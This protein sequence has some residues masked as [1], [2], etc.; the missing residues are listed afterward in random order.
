M[1]GRKSNLGRGLFSLPPDAVAS[2][3]E[4]HSDRGE[5]VADSVRG[6][7]VFSLAGFLA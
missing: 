5:R 7:E 6:R 2:V 4:D 1:E 3:L